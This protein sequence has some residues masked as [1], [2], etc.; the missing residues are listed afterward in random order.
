MR[1]EHELVVARPPAE[2]F[3]FLADPANLPAWQSNLVEVRKGAGEGLGAR[4]TEVRSLLGKHLEQTLEV[5]AYEPASRLDLRV[6]DGPVPLSVSHR[7]EAV[8]GGTRIVFVGEGE[9]AGPFKLAGPL[10][11]RAVK[12]QSEQD[13][14]RLQTLLAG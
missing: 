9:P 6:V 14:A 3:A 1:F 4:H 2:V 5:T 12:K 8:D 13:F 11:A 7:L 10:L